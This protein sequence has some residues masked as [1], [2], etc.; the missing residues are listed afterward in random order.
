[1]PL[2]RVQGQIDERGDLYAIINGRWECMPARWAEMMESAICQQQGIPM[3]QLWRPEV[4][5]VTPRLT[6][7]G[8]RLLD[9]LGVGHEEVV[10]IDEHYVDGH[11]NGVDDRH[12]WMWRLDDRDRR[13]S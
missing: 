9:E 13:W 8:K 3:R 4:Y 10:F 6:A 5:K 2:I 12:E 7:R 1:M 11:P